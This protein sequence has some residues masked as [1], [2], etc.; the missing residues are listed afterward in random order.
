MM[1][2][3]QFQIDRVPD[4]ENVRVPTSRGFPELT[5]EMLQRHAEMLGPGYVD[6]V[7]LDLIMSFHSFV[8]RIKDRVIVVDTCIGNDKDRPNHVILGWNRRRGDYLERLAALG[9]KPEDVDVVMCTHL[10]VDH[11]GWNTRLVNGKWVPTFRNARYV[12][13]DTEYR[14]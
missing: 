6:P 8:V 9:V 2:I 14:H 10:H 11:V 13:A 7:T 12:M 1:K 3:G 5:R 4:L